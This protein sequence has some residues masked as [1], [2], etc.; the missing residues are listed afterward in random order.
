MAA[1]Q[2]NTQLQVIELI[3][4]DVVVLRP[5]D[6]V[7]QGQRHHAIVFGVAVNAGAGGEGDHLIA[8]GDHRVDHAAKGGF[9][10]LLRHAQAL[11]ERRQLAHGN[12]DGFAAADDVLPVQQV[13]TRLLDA[14]RAHQKGGVDARRNFTRGDAIFF[15]QVEADRLAQHQAVDAVKNKVRQRVDARVLKRADRVADQIDRL[16]RH[17]GAERM[18]KL[19]HAV[20]ID[21][22]RAADLDNG[23]VLLQAVGESLQMRRYAKG[24]KQAAFTQMR[25]HN[26]RHQS[27][28]DLALYRADQALRR[29]A[30]VQKQRVL[31][32]V[33]LEQIP[34]A[35]WITAD[36]VN[37]YVTAGG[38]Y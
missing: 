6:A 17:Q 30:V 14:A 37:L 36:R 21:E 25:H 24:F 11:V 18:V 29:L 15:H 35:R 7:A 10:L 26:V 38:M 19:R 1:A 2:Q 33:L 5:L 20:K 34:R 28:G 27:V 9:I 3:H 12:G 32:N 13:V 31:L 23:V 4:D 22:E 8:F 16:F